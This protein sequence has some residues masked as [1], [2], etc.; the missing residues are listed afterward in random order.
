MQA[1]QH[2]QSALQSARLAQDRYMESEALSSLG[3]L[4]TALGEYTQAEESLRASIEIATQ[5]KSPVALA[6]SQV[7]LGY[8]LSFLG[9]F[10]DALSSLEEA[11]LLASRIDHPRLPDLILCY[12][13]HARLMRNQP[14]DMLL[15]CE[16]VS[17]VLSAVQRKQSPT[18]EKQLAAMA[19]SYRAFANLRLQKIN[20]AL[21]DTEAA[22]LLRK[23]V[24]A[25]ESGEEELL[26][27]R[28]MVLRA[29]QKEEPLTQALSE[30]N[31]FVISR[32]AQLK[33]A[34]AYLRSYA[35]RLILEMQSMSQGDASPT[36]QE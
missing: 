6:F 24:G 10:D 28:L 30:A 18:S 34:S 13:A 4:S 32:A 3:S 1:Y 20:E 8:L 14:G 33:D 35:P 16:D 29:E 15:V 5:I 12:R 31:E 7:N 27:Y 21:Q 23:A 9:R 36:M 19:Y 25:L 11:A 17:N 22:F 26:Y 2:A